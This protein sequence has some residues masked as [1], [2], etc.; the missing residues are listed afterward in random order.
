MTRVLE[1]AYTPGAVSEGLFQEEQNYLTPGLQ[2]VSLYSKIALKQGRGPVI[3]DEDGN[4]YI[5][6]MAGIGVASIGHAHPE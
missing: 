5:D 2:T 4:K 6:L 3:E 1:K